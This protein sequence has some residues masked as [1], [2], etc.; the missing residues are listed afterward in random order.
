MCLLLGC[1]ILVSRAQDRLKFM[2]GYERFQKITRESTNVFKSGALTVTWLEGGHA[3]DY[4]K[5]GKPYRYDLATR[6]ATELPSPPT[7]S[8]ATNSARAERRPPAARDQPRPERGR[9]YTVAVSPDRQFTARFHDQNVWL[10]ATNSTNEIAVTTEGDETSR[11]K[12]GSASWVYGEELFQSTAMWWSSNSQKLAFYRF[13][14]SRVPKFYLQLDQTKIQSTAD[15]EAYAKAG[16]TNPV[17]DLFIYDVATKKTVRVDA[18]DGKPFDN[19]VVGHYVY[20]VSWSR[21]G[22]LL[23]HRTNRRQNIMELCAADPET[24]KVRVIVRETWPAS[25]TDN[26]PAMQFF[27]DGQRF[28]WTSE[29]NG[30]KMSAMVWDDERPGLTLQARYERAGSQVA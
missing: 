19:S 23:F 3:F 15:V 18:R 5:D 27:K 14:E 21:N 4:R 16:G 10:R 22:E 6:T 28:V 13:D 20:G 8:P 2:P 12:F 11:V 9:Q 29:R 17:V 30:W 7:N 25:W 24:G 26:S 1:S